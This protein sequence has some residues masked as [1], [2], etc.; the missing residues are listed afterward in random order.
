MLA[1]RPETF[2][3]A[4][5]VFLGRLTTDGRSPRRRVYPTKRWYFVRCR[6]V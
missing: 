4:A 1:P 3:D 2:P 5:A 6:I